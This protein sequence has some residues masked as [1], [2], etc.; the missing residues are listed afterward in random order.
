MSDTLTEKQATDVQN[1]M[2]SNVYLPA[3]VHNFNQ[4][5]A[6]VGL[7]PI[8]TEQQLEEALQIAS[9]LEQ[10]KHASATT[11][12]PVTKVANAM[13]GKNGVVKQATVKTAQAA[14]NFGNQVVQDQNFLQGLFT[15]L[16]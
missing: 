8:Q 16:K 11:N 13:R 14:T 6:S 9:M 10:Q 5:A 7:P 3:F 4:K 1:H 15:A 2:F 12:H